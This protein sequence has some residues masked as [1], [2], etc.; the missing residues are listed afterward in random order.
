MCLRYS[1]PRLAT[2][3]QAKA[4]PPSRQTGARA[5][6]AHIDL[7]QVI[8]ATHGLANLKADLAPVI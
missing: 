1:D 6:A 2:V 4:D 3:L 8:A 7:L 5:Q